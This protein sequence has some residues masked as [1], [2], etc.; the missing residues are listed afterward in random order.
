MPDM[1]SIMELGAGEGGV[2][3]LGQRGLSPRAVILK[4]T[5]NLPRKDLGGGHLGGKLSLK[6]YSSVGENIARLQGVGRM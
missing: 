1:R 2:S 3:G 5:T 4:V 6:L